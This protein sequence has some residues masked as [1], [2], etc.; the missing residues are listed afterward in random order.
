MGGAVATLALQRK[1]ATFPTVVA[2][3]LI[4][5]ATVR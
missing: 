1:S 2:L 5:V 4:V 3:L